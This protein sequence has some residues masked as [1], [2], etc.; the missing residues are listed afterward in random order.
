[1]TETEPVVIEEEATTLTPAQQREHEHYEAI[2]ARTQEVCNARALWAAAK[3]R[4]SALKKEFD[5][6]T[7]ELLD[8][9]R[10]GPDPQQK[11]PL[12][13]EPS[14][15]S[16]A[17]RDVEVGELDIPDSLAAKLIEHGLHTLGEL[18]DF[19]KARRELAELKGI[20]GAKQDL[21]ADAFAKYGQNHPEVFGEPVEKVALKTVGADGEESWEDLE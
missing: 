14:A 19:W 9:T 3:D 10:G 11:L 7:T 12:S 13:D 21:V 2:K 16:D 18:S 20:G 4:A 8:F 5:A 1:M 17:W 6:L 15:V